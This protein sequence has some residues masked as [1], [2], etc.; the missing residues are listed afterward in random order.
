MNSI[1]NVATHQEVNLRP[2]Q[3]GMI[4]ISTTHIPKHTALAL[5]NDE[6]KSG[7]PDLWDTLSHVYFHEYGWI[8]WCSSDAAEAVRESHPELAA[9]IRRCLDINAACLKLDCD[10]DVV[11]ELATFDW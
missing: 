2:F 3:V 8:V 6:G 11:P 9:L 1:Q 7:K 5:G 4:N 10:A